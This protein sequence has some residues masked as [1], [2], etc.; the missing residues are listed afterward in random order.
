MALFPRS[1]PIQYEPE[2]WPSRSYLRHNYMPLAPAPSLPRH[3]SELD[4]YPM[5]LHER[6]RWRME[7]PSFSWPGSFNQ[8]LRSPA[9]MPLV[10]AN[11]QWAAPFNQ[12]VSR[13][14][15]EMNKMMENFTKMSALPKTADDFRVTENFRLDNPVIQDVDGR[16]RF[17]L[18]FDVRQFKPEEIHVKTAG[19]QLTVHAKH[20]DKDSGKSSYR[21]YSRQFILPKE[22]N[23]E[24]LSSKLSSDGML[25][26]EAPLP[27][28]EGPRE[29]LIPIEHGK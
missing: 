4:P 18:Q 3:F 8:E 24:L 14:S 2:F 6:P 22:V 19:N 17:S 25:T 29:K 9:A 21:E 28:L 13:M 12:E 27:S 10:S 7:E 16:R 15:A 26:I 23:A 11:T 20:E 1:I 5:E